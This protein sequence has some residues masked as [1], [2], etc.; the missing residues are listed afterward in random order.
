MSPTARILSI[1]IECSPCFQRE[2]P[3]G[4]LKCLNDLTPDRVF[5][6]AQGLIEP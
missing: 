4:H 2:C 1:G 5:D 3:L 6:A